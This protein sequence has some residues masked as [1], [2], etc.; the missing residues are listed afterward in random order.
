M[1]AL[2][3]ERN[4]MRESQIATDLIKKESYALLINVCNRYVQYLAGEYPVYCHDNPSL[5]CGVDFEGLRNYLSFRIPG[6]YYDYLGNVVPP[7]GNDFNQFA[8]ID[9]IE[10]IGQNITDIKVQDYHSFFQHHHIRVCETRTVFTKYR[11]DINDT[12]A[13]T[14]LLYNLNESKQIERITDADSQ[15]AANASAIE[16]I[17]EPGL[18]QL[19]NDSIRFFKNP[20]PEIYH[21]SVE[22]IWDALE[23][24]KTV[25]GNPGMSKKES[26]SELINRMSNGNKTY[27]DL[28]NSEFK[29]LTDIGN[30]FRIRHHEIA[31]IDISD[32]LYYGYFF[33]RCFALICLALKYI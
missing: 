28:F 3:T 22:K 19:V 31:K 7:T 33:H 17:N 11:D 10:F 13:L 12:F 2:F 27:F 18:K 24:I 21:T 9:Y 29:A 32:E 16:G 26:V 15:I 23:R 4:N 30:N 1:D 5:V 25:L 6:L 8:L 14:R 20:R